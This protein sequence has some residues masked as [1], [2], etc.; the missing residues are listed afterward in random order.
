MEPS[1]KEMLEVGESC[2]LKTVEEAYNNYM[3]HYDMFFLISK[4]NEQ[5]HTLHGEMKTLRLIER[6]PEKV[7]KWRIKEDVTIAEAKERL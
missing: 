7:N 1:V 6:V 4:Y 3:N 2:G 5:L